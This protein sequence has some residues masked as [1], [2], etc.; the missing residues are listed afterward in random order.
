MVLTLTVRPVRLTELRRKSKSSDN[1]KDWD[2]FPVF[3][4]SFNFQKIQNLVSENFQKTQKIPKI[5]KIQI[6]QKI[7]KSAPVIF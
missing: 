6:I 5:P 7:L 4:F 2:L 1:S 3:S